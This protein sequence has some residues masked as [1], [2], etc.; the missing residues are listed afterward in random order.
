M[1][2]WSNSADARRVNQAL[3][4][5][6]IWAGQISVERTGLEETFLAMTGAGTDIEEAADAPA[7]G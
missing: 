7:A 5:G 6:G 1:R 2:C 3:G 4:R